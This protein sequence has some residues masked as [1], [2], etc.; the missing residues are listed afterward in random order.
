MRIFTVRMSRDQ[1]E[2][3]LDHFLNDAEMGILKSEF[4]WIH[5]IVTEHLAKEGS[6]LLK[7]LH[8]SPN[9]EDLSWRIECEVQS[10]QEAKE[11]EKQ[12]LRAGGGE[13]P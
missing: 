4:A 8:A 1:Q 7:I 6:S 3:A 11:N 2:V 9:I 12:Q 5:R 10:G 13:T